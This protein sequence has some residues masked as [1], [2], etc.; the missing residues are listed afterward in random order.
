MTEGNSSRLFEAKIAD[1]FRLC[2]K[3]ASPR[4][5]TFLDSAEQLAAGEL[6][7]QYYDFNCGFFGGYEGAQRKI[8]GV[9]PSWC[10]FDE[11]EF[12]VSAVKITKKYSRTLTH[13]DY[14]G[15][16]LSTGLDRSK[17]GDISVCEDG[18]YIFVASD[19]TEYITSSITKIANTGVSVCEIPLSEAEIPEQEFKEIHAVCASRRLDALVSGALNASRS[20]AQRLISGGAVSVNHAVCERVDFLPRQGDVLSVR[21]Y[22][23]FIFSEIGA[24]TRSGKY[25]MTFLKYV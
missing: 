15:T 23:R 22:G 5:S 21:G 24:E 4:F 25:H 9:F 7:A 2:E 17:I 16:V 20:A 1:L 13:R 19:M 6:T 18:A 11:E 12:P 14:L 3:Y 10:E 8:L